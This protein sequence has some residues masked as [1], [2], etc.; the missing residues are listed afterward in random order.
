GIGNTI[1]GTAVI[2]VTIAIDAR[3]RVT[4]IGTT[5]VGATLPATGNTTG[6]RDTEAPRPVDARR[7]PVD[8]QPPPAAAQR[9]PADVRRLPV[10]V[11][12]RAADRFDLA[13]DSQPRC[14]PPRS[15]RGV[16]WAARELIVG[17][18]HAHQ[19]LPRIDP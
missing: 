11:R 9:P 7:P 16:I 1:L 5:A 17:A 8:A 13:I 4:T 19:D 3:H 15:P 14:R 2:L 12:H 6:R 18:T 10:A